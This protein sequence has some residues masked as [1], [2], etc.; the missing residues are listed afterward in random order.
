MEA[1]NSAKP[2]P[3]STTYRLKEASPPIG[4]SGY[5]RGQEASRSDQSVR[6][7]TE[8]LGRSRQGTRQ[9]PHPRDEKCSTEVVATIARAYTEGITRSAWKAQYRSAQQVLTTE[10][11]PRVIVPTMVFGGKEASRCASPHNDP[12]VVE[13]KIASAIVQQILIDMGS[14]VDIITWDCI[15]KLVHPERDI[16]PL[17]HPILRFSG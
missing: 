5:Q 14:L 6:S 3:S 15:K 12:L 9:P 1:A 4:R 17:V 7:Y 13:M 8:Q 2:L 11:R 16:V 10:Q